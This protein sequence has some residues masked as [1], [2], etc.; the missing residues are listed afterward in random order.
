MSRRGD[1]VSRLDA[2]GWVYIYDPQ[3]TRQ[4][5]EGEADGMDEFHQKESTQS[6]QY[7]KGRYRNN[8]THAWERQQLRERL[9][10]NARYP[11]KAE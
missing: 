2:D 7:S 6:L 1:Y 4:E 10:T 9:Q 8:T 5:F 11:W 3:P